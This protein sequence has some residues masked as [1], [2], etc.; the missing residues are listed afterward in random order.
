MICTLKN[1]EATVSDLLASL[2]NQTLAAKEIIIVDGGSSDDTIDVI[3]SFT[4][5][6]PITLLSFPGSNIAKGRNEAIKKS[7]CDIIASTDGGCRL[8]P[9]WLENITKP[10]KQLD[11]DVVCG[12]YKPWVKNEFEEV[13]SYLIFPV[14]DDINPH[15]FLPSSRSL[16]FRKKVWV[17]VGGY[18]EWL[19]TAE[20]TLFDLKMKESGKKFALSRDAIV[21]WRVRDSNTRVFRQFF[22]Y[23][24][25][26]GEARIFFGRYLPRY[27][28]ILLFGFLVAMF[29]YNLAIWVIIVAVFFAG[30]WIK[31]LRKVR[32]GS[33]LK[34]FL[35]AIKVALTIETGLFLG[36]LRGRFEFLW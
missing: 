24:K 19:K 9:D 18:P 12:V 6:L 4:D 11:V 10:L 29:W 34:R 23:A 30:L 20:D 28:A 1:E 13:T 15:S 25:G 31:Y 16:A 26:D 8:S 32:K 7:H 3:N 17:E 2:V 27:L 33:S 21:Y 22:N 14:V 36:Y 5:K 35:I